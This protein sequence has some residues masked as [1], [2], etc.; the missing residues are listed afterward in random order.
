MKR[1]HVIAGIG[2]GVV[3][4]LAGCLGIFGDD[5]T[6][7]EASPVS[8]SSDASEEAGYEHQQTEELLVEREFEA[9]GQSETVEVVNYQVEYDKG[10]DMGPLGRQRGAV[11]IT[12]STPKVNVLE[13]EF[14]PV[15]DMSTGELVEMVQDSYDGISNVSSAET[16]DVTILEQETVQERFTAEADFDG[17][18]FDVYLHISEA[19]E[20]G[21]DFVVAIGVY[22]QLVRME[23]EDNILALME[24]VVE[25][26]PADEDDESEDDEAENGDEADDN[27]DNDETDDEDGDDEADDNGDD[28][29]EDSDDEESEDDE[30]DDEEEDDLLP[31]E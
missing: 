28:D 8:V 15:E 11:F 26:E 21:D 20:A 4:S 17:T 1:R 29:G 31:L 13:Q 19:V 7:F 12:L 10:V 9:A 3:G 5:L 25:E 23:E 30:A 22:P 27:G 2:T 14:N 24:S 6:R 18:N 16:G